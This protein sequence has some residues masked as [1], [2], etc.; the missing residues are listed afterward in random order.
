MLASILALGVTACA[1]QPADEPRP[2]DFGL[3]W[4]DSSAEYRAVAL[5]VYRAAENDLPGFLADPDWSALPDQRDAADK[6]PAVIF[7]VD[8]TVVSG[9]DFQLGYEPPFTNAKHEAWN[10]THEAVPVPGFP[11]FA[12]AA[13]EAGVTLFFVTNRPCEPVGNDPCPQEKTAI[14]DVA[15]AG[16]ETDAGHMMLAFER[17]EWTKEK[18]TRREHVAETHRVIMV[19][20]D[21]LGDFIPCTRAEPAAP[22]E[23][24]ASIA[25]RDALVDQYRDYFGHG[26]YILPNPMHGSWTTVR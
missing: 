20:G 11:R 18:S 7:D 6:P 25:S 9:V 1:H 22:C 2:G 26:W 5:Q 14:D 12:R 4:V 10:S 17:P 24:G 3:E 19:F 13:R 15:E 16:I 8:E 21:D 23:T